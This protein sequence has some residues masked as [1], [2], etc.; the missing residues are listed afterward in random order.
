MLF[1]LNG[2]EAHMYVLGICENYV[3]VVLYITFIIAHLASP[4][5]DG[6]DGIMYGP[7]VVIF[8]VVARHF[9]AAGRCDV[10]FCK[11]DLKIIPCQAGGK[12]AQ[13]VHK[14]N[15]YRLRV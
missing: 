10:F 11:T 3:E 14:C 4:S 6:L 8:A 12:D 13:N 9:H 7:V 2:I 5:A 15:G 1:V